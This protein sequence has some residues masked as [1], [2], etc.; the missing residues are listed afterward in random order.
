MVEAIAV[1]AFFVAL[2]L[3]GIG[4]LHPPLVVRWTDSPSRKQALV[5]YGALALSAA[6]GTGVVVVDVREDVAQPTPQMAL[7]EDVPVENAGADALNVRAR[8]HGGHVHITNRSDEGW[9]DCRM[10]INPGLVRSGWRQTVSRIGAGETV[11][12]SLLAFRRSDGR[13]F[14][15]ATHDVQRLRV[16][17]RAPLGT[18]VWL[19]E[20]RTKADG[21]HARRRIRRAS[22]AAASSTLPGPKRAVPR[23]C[24][25]P[26]SAAPRT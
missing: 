19:G 14:D 5:V 16:T 23:P 2:A 24:R 22:Q 10:D 13:R 7:D 20:V 26:L 11:S 3:L 6:M 15:P 4:L 21:H 9:T 17:C 12:G 8:L 18:R 25:S 1:T